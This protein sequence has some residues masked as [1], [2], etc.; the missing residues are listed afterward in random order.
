[1]PPIPT[2]SN[3]SIMIASKLLIYLAMV[4]AHTLNPLKIVV[5][6]GEMAAG[7]MAI[8]ATVQTKAI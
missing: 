3:L 8:K 4:V 2:N 7:T 5:N 6:A 1:M